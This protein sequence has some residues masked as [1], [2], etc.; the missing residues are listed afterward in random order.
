LTVIDGKRKLI[1]TICTIGA[2]VMNRI[3]VD[4]L[5]LY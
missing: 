4:G 1:K 2:R 3:R 5:A